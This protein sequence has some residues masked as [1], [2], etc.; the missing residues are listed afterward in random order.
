VKPCR[1][2]FW[3][4]A[5]AVFAI[6]GPAAA[7]GLPAGRCVADPADVAW[8][9]ASTAAWTYTETRI[10][11]LPAAR[12]P[13][14]VFF[15]KVCVY[16]PRPQEHGG[17]VALPDGNIIPAHI[18]S[19]A[20]PY[21]H[22]R[23]AFFVMAL[24][25]V[26]RAEGAKSEF[27][28]ETLTTAVRIHETTHT[29]QFYAFSPRIAALTKKWGLPDDITDDSLQDHFA[30]DPAYVA[31]YQ[32]ERDLLFQAVAEPDRSQARAL[33]GRA[34][35]MVRARQTRWFTGEEAKWTDLD[36]AF[37]TLEGVAQFAAYRWLT[38]PRGGH[39]A[40]AVALN[41]FRRGG[42]FWTQ[43]E[44]FA[45]FLVVDRLVPNWR[46]RAFAANPE[47]AYELLARAAAG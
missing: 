12:G 42:R 33:A 41:N 1:I 15:D 17:K 32:A 25:S 30:K 3:A 22:D 9:T 24:P 34:L 13:L 38:D 21:D 40:P 36:D 11:R 44:G 20:A 16:W 19:F 5:A 8:I 39:I 23:K 4:A 6:A 37:L 46:D 27:G 35:A 31:A 28:L 43:D 10:L 2:I 26:W 7:A 18:V 29:R 47:G 45:L 14:L